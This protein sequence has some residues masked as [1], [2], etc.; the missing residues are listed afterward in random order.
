MFP[1]IAQSRLVLYI[2]MIHKKGNNKGLTLTSELHTIEEVNSNNKI[3][4]AMNDGV[5]LLLQARFADSFEIYGPSAKVFVEGSLQSLKGEELM[6]FNENE[7][8][9][10]LVDIGKSKTIVYDKDERGQLIEIKFRPQLK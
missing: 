1:I 6:V 4:V 9:K 8:E 2:T 10:L 5:K 7:K 3:E